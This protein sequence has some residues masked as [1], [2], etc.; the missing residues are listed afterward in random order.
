MQNL[1]DDY[2]LPSWPKTKI[3]LELWNAVMRDIS[4][5]L[6]ARELLEAS[7]EL[8]QQEGIQAAL[9]Y[10]QI[11]VAPQLA[12]LQTSINLAQ[13]QIDKIVIDGIS[14]NSAKLGGQLPSYYATAQ[15]LLTGLEQNASL[16]Q[17]RAELIEEDVATLLSAIGN[18][19]AFA[20]NVMAA[21][22]DKLGKGG[23]KMTG[24][25]D[26]SGNALKNA[27]SGVADYIKGLITSKSSALVVSVAAGEFKG[28]GKL[29]VNPAPFTKNLNAVW[30]A[31]SGNGGRLEAAALAANATYHLH[32][33]IKD[34]DGSPDWGYSTSAT[35]PTIP[36]GYTWVGRF[37]IVE[38]DATGANIRGY[39]QS[40]NKC[41]LDL[42]VLEASVGGSFAKLLATWVAAPN[43]ISTDILVY[44]LAAAVN[45]NPSSA[46]INVFDGNSGGNFNALSALAY[47]SSNS[48]GVSNVCIGPVR[49]N[50][51][52]QVYVSGSMGGGGG[53]AI[54]NIIGWIDYQLPPRVY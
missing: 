33:L 25:I 28:N 44:A 27:G 12:S 48:T 40:G 50:A 30:A 4:A 46:Q 51:S 35:A 3:D 17:E 31:G 32:A 26:L 36:A 13:E 42:Q 39:T 15:A 22:G 23:G 38:L 54:T 20:V 24:S 2:Q 47:A 11:T 41:T 1:L 43:G 52:K 16:F 18:D 37:W 14:P 45:V 5:R 9:D 34:S 7:F 19:P 6:K 49:T 8:L 10:V 29:F 53:S 21:L